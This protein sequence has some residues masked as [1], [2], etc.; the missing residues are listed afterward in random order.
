MGQ[1][2]DTARDLDQ[3]YVMHTYGDREPALFVRGQGMH[4][5]DDEGAEYLDFLAGI[6]VCPLGH[7]DPA[8]VAAVQ[9]QAG[10]VLQLS[11]YFQEEHRGEVAAELARIAGGDS[12]G[13]KAFFGNSGA[14]ANECAMKVARRWA[15][16]N[17]GPQ[18]QTIVAL[19]GSFHGRTM[20]TL[21][22][23]EQGW[24]QE[25]FAPLPG[26]FKAV[27]RNDVAALEAAV[28]PDVCAIMLEP[29]QGE[30]GVW[31]MTDEYLAAVRRIADERGCLV[32]FD[33]VQTGLYRCGEPFCF[34]TAKTA[35]DNGVVP[36]IV[37][38][39]KGIASGIPCGACLARG[40][41][42]DILKPGQ[43]GS[44]FGGGP[45]AM[46]AALATLTQLADRKLG[47][48]ARQVGAYLKERLAGLPYVTDVRGKG[49]MV[50]ATV[51]GH[52][53][54]DLVNEMLARHVVINACNDTTLRF[55]PPLIATEADVDQLVAALA[56]LA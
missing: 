13:W 2:F 36:D 38:V 27:P 19:E 23:T 56:Q 11:N 30:S 42:A 28:T 15:I 50:G 9:D 41:A 43:Q 51:E 37:T 31:P 46:A 40:E 49:L 17:K 12:Y 45:V 10:K 18:C 32:I 16:V 53:A 44:T 5:Y 39:A 47:E 54:H 6:A 34:Q 7:A 25:P 22:A 3:R 55:L 8:V 14:E 4:L 1:L 33:E 21:A 20:E 35:G 26:G 29:I 52:D 48:N 24:L